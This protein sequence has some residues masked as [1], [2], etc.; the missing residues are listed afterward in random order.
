MNNDQNNENTKKENRFINPIQP[1]TLTKDNEKEEN[2]N[3]NKNDNDES[4]RI[5]PITPIPGINIEPQK[6]D[7][8]EHEL[9]TLIN[10]KNDL[11]INS[12]MNFDSSLNLQGINKPEDKEESKKNI[13][14]EEN[15][16]TS[17][18]KTKTGRFLN[19]DSHN[20]NKEDKK[21]SMNTEATSSKK[22]LVNMFLFS[23][24]VIGIILM[25]IKIINKK[26]KND[27][28][29]AKSFLIYSV[30]MI[31]IIILTLFLITNVFYDR[32]YGDDYQPEYNN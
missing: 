4:T 19:V 13:S 7:N 2:I 24:P 6:N 27:S 21:K 28:N 8:N 25:I 29:F 32:I 16:E 14:K 5:I 9:G 26:D 10:D 12:S 18:D 17:E 30:S 3:E 11:L 23:I 20:K 22:Y 15:K 1:Q 31:A